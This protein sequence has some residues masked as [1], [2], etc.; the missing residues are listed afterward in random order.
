MPKRAF[1][2]FPSAE[3]D[4]RATVA[5]GFV[6]GLLSGLRA[7]GLDPAPFLHAAGLPPDTLE[8]H[9]ARVPIEHYVALYNTVARELDDE[10]FA[11]F[12][13]PL[14]TGTFEFLCRALLGSRDL[15]EAL[16]RAARFLR[17]VLPDLRVTL[18]RS[19]TTGRLEIAE[20]RR[21]KSAN[22]PRRIFAFEWLLRL[23]HALASWFAARPIALLEV[24]F[25]YAAPRHVEDY[26]SIYTANATFGAKSLVAVL[27]A[28]SL[29]LPC[30]RSEADLEAFLVGGPGKIAMLYRRDRDVARAVRE[31][32]AASIGRGA[33]LD[34]A[35]RALNMSARTLHRRLDDE[36]TTFREVK[37]SVRREIALERL[38]TSAA[39]VAQI[40]T[41]LGYSEPSAF[42]RAFQGWTGV[43]PSMHRRRLRIK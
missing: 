18:E 9:A 33:T 28:A 13:A 36:G 29:A 35:A 39:S 27:D 22:D 12:S 25:P 3:H 38:E 37:D 6:R 7:R 19:G 40:A 17:I 42:F 32:L 4:H 34:G 43:A 31:F 14:R 23:L 2:H 8:P 15:G 26:A 16:E 11:L 24:R 5:A 41:E 10:G 20:G 21:L 30:R 1:E